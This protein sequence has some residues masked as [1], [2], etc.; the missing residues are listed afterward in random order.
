MG[1]KL[2]TVFLFFTLLFSCLHASA[3]PALQVAF[4]LF[5]PFHYYNDEGKLE[6][7][8]YDIITEALTNRLGIELIWSPYP[9]ARCQEN[10]KTGKADILLTVPTSERAQYTNTHSKPFYTKNLHVFTY[11]THPRLEMIL[12]IKDIDDIKKAE[13]SVITYSGNGWHNNNIEAIGIKS[14]M[15]SSLPNVWKMLAG[16][17]GDLVIEWPTA[18]LPDIKKHKLEQSIIDTNIVLS[19]MH[20]HLLLRKNSKQEDIL[21]KF[22]AVIE[23][24]QNDGTIASI[25]AKY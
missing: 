11:K 9:W 17:R 16:K 2:I 12:K 25:T 15:S 18:A 24:M 5:T 4:P 14:Y 1:K 23:A 19:S 8:F 21:D 22:D 3:K 6:G 13:L 7:I 20:F 10:V